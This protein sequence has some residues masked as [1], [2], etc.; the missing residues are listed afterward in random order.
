MP[1]WIQLSKIVNAEFLT[2]AWIIKERAG[3][4]DAIDCFSGNQSVFL[5][6]GKKIHQKML[7]FLKSFYMKEYI[8]QNDNFLAAMEIS[9]P[10]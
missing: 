4:V 2:R 6:F 1:L 5:F 8:L 7:K 10:D 3:Y 9:N